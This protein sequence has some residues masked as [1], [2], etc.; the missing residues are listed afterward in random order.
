MCTTCWQLVCEQEINKH[1]SKDGKTKHS[2]T[3][4]FAGMAIAEKQSLLGLFKAH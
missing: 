3:T 4:T 2:M 1:K